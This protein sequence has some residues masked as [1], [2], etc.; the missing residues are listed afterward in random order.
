MRLSSNRAP[1]PLELALAGV[2]MVAAYR[3]GAVEAWIMRRAIR[4]QFGDFGQSRHWRNVVP[5]FIQEDCTA[6]KLAPALARNP[7]RL[8]VAAATARGFFKIDAIM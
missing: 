5:E 1:R 6:E 4:N 7:Q 2:P 8:A 3:A